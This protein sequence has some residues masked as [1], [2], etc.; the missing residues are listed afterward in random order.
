MNKQAI[1]REIKAAM[2]LQLRQPLLTGRG[3]PFVARKNNSPFE[4]V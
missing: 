4:R 1:L 2:K 3:C